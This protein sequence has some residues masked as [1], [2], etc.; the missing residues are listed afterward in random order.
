MAGQPPAGG[1]SESDDEEVKDQQLA[2][3]FTSNL[4]SSSESA[5]RFAALFRA[6]Y[7]ALDERQ[8]SYLQ[9]TVQLVLQAGVAEQ[10]RQQLSEMGINAT[11]K[12]I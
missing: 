6:F 12:N 4:L 1:H 8:I 11:L 2:F 10:I 5:D 9:G 7:M 3:S